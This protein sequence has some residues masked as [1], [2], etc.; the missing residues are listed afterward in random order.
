MIC[1]PATVSYEERPSQAPADQKEALRIAAERNSLSTW[2]PMKPN[3]HFIQVAITNRLDPDK[4]P[5]STWNQSCE[6]SL[7][8]SP[9]HWPFLGLLKIF[10]Q[11]NLAFVSNPCQQ[12]VVQN[13]LPFMDYDGLIT[14]NLKH[15]VEVSSHGEERNLPPPSFLSILRKSWHHMQLKGVENYLSKKVA[16]KSSRKVACM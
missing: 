12:L 16:W 4:D 1:P 10:L 8:I 15:I 13:P 6:S 11:R 9:V 2:R 3:I 14:V 7:G 5:D